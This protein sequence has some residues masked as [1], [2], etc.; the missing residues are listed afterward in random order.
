M[1]Y[2]CFDVSIEDKIAHVRLS[3]P[4]A[5]NSMTK[6]FWDELPEIVN[7]LDAGAEARAIVLSSTGKHF[8]AGMDLAVFGDGSLG[9]GGGEVGRKRANLRRQVL[10]L[11]NTFSCLDRARIPVLAAIQGACIGGGVDMISSCDMR[12][13]TEDAYFCIQEINIGM[14]A[15]VGTFPRLPKLIPEG[16]VRELAYTG[17]RLSAPEAKETGLVNRVY[18]DHDALVAGVTE[19]AK[20]IA[21]RSPLAVWGSK[22]M[23]NYARDHSIGDALDYIATWQTGM[24]QPADMMEA[25]K[26]KQEQRD[27]DY[28]DL[29]PLKNKL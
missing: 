7:A 6:E 22:E 20:E 8:T 23:I 2:T 3:R 24:F 1:P 11:Q 29:L 26:A 5:F 21:E 19:I 15:D 25:F 16:L 18:P 28:E 9:G 4:E 14:T 12:Y 17:R 27:P 10:H 13:C